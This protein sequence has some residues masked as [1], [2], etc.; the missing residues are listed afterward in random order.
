MD[1]GPRLKKSDCRTEGL[2]NGL[3]ANR[4]H[5][6]ISDHSHSH[7]AGVQIGLEECFGLLAAVA[8]CFRIAG[9]TS[10]NCRCP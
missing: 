7:P 4:Q 5:V 2:G 8:D 10:M 9:G 6:L 1:R 3:S